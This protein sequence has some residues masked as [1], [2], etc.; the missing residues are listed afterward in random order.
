MVTSNCHANLKNL[1][2]YFFNIFFLC[3]GIFIF[4]C[5][6]Y[7]WFKAITDRATFRHITFVSEGEMQMETHKMDEL[8]EKMFTNVNH[9]IECQRFVMDS[10]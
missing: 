8:T 3:F 6:I 2:I 5:Y 9:L 10:V 4:P 1:L 7:N